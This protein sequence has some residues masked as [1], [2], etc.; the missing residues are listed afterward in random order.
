MEKK[1][2]LDIGET[3]SNASGATIKIIGRETLLE[4]VYYDQDG[5]AYHED[6]IP[7]NGDMRKRLIIL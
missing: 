4:S 7:W 1:I 6:G 2:G 5:M 3:Y